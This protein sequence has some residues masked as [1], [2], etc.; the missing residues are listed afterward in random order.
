M[1]ESSF[2]DQFAGLKRAAQESKKRTLNQLFEESPDRS[3]NY[4][5]RLKGLN[6]DFSKTHINQ[7]LLTE[8]E[9][10]AL[11]SGLL[12]QRDKLLTGGIV[13]LTE[14]RPALHADMR[15]ATPI[16][17]E[18]EDQRRAC[19]QFAEQVRQAEIAPS[20]GDRYQHIIH[21][22]IGGSALGP[23][24]LLDALAYGQ[25]SV[26][27]LNEP[28]F[29]AHCIANI[30]GHALEPVMQI[31][32]PNR[33]LVIV[34]SKTFTTTETL[35]NANTLIDW[36]RSQGIENPLSQIVAVTASPN[37]AK[38]F[39]IAEDHILTFPEGLG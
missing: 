31:C 21:L 39:G 10:L 27:K 32:D 8:F 24:L 15:S 6:F 12:Q 7:S 11:D 35:S 16:T 26:N 20:C 25:G 4:S 13:N 22:G 9:K 5:F 28:S 38:S 30:D 2:S 14:K 23:Q 18:I 33:T 19:Y 29:D 36:M 37:Q 17:T 1:T 34:A 3:E